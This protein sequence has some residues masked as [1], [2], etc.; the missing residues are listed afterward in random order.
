MQHTGIVTTK[1]EF[2]PGQ[3]VW[4]DGRDVEADPPLTVRRINLWDLDP[5]PGSARGRV[6]RSL[7]HGTAVK[8]MDARFLEGEN[9]WYYRVRYRM[10]AGWVPGRFLCGERPGVLGEL[11]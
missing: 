9:R 4:I 1:R 11:V 7:N 2:E 8:V 3:R 6:L 5:V 10:K